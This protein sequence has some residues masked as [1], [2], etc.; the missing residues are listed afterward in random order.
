MNS[1]ASLFIFGGLPTL[2]F[3][4]LSQIGLPS[5]ILS[6]SCNIHGLYMFPQYLHFYEVIFYSVLVC[7]VFC[8]LGGFI[9]FIVSNSS[10]DF[11]TYMSGFFALSALAFWPKLI[12]THQ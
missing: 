11:V 2:G 1:S 10:L 9:P 7:Q 4:T 8:F 6:I 3:C 12:L 5:H